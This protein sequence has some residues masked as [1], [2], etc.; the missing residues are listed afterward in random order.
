M[1]DLKKELTHEEHHSTEIEIR[2]LN[3]DDMVEAGVLDAGRCVD[4]MEEVVGL[5]DKGDAILGGPKHDEHGCMLYFPKKSPIPDFPLNDA[6]DRRFIAMPAYVGGRFH[7][8]GCK[9]YGSNGRN[10]SKGL[11][12]SILMMSLNDVETGAP[13]AYMSANLLSSMRTGSMPGLAA[14]LLANPDSKELALIGPGVINKACLMAILSKMKEIDTIRIKGSSVTS[15]TALS[16]K[17]FIEANYPQIKNIKICETLEEAIRGADIVSEAV[18]CK[19]G[20]WPRYEVEWFKPGATVIS[21]ST[22]NMDY[23]DIAP[24]R[25]VVDNYGMYENYAIED[26]EGYDEN[27]ERKHTGCM[28]EDFVYMIED[29]IIT[30]GSIDQLGEI[31]N[32]KKPG[33]KSHDEIILVS[34]EGMP[35]EDVAWGYECYKNAVEK[36]IGEELKLWDAP[37][38]F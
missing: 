1:A 20:Q 36:G 38:A 5:L 4:V 14:K 37:R 15:K 21:A 30:R 23:H 28:G 25:K 2:W 12:R 24:I 26:E 9:W 19:E 16:M 27:G 11:P 13:L 18:S 10:R 3:E 31:I 22:F 34:I 32:G 33:R 6:A 35:I 17:D 8:A 29:G 7:L